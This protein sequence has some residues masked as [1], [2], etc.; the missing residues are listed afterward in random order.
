MLTQK[1]LRRLLH[2]NP[3]TGIFTWRNYRSSV[4]QAGEVAGSIKPSG[5]VTVHINRK[6]F[7]TSGKGGRLCGELKYPQDAADQNM[8]GVLNL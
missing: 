5:Y 6:T 7:G 2:Y 4:A 8:W 1:E 3:A